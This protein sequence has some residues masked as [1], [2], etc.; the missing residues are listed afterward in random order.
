MWNLSQLSA[1][2]ARILDK[3]Y[4]FPFDPAKHQGVATVRLPDEAELVLIADNGNIGEARQGITSAKLA[5]TW[6]HF[7]P[8]FDKP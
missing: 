2:E 8:W 7:A 6:F 5:M 1:I 3:I 4:A